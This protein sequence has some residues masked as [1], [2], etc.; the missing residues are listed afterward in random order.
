MSGTLLALCHP[1]TCSLPSLALLHK[2]FTL[3]KTSGPVYLH[4]QQGVA[5]LPKIQVVSGHS[6]TVVEIKENRVHID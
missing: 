5:Q 1:S 4:I 2:S 3:G 6:S